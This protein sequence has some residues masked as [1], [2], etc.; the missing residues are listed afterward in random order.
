MNF[1]DNS[2][3]K[4]VLVTFASNKNAKAYHFTSDVIAF[5]DK[6]DAQVWARNLSNKKV[7][8]ITRAQAAELEISG[9]DLSKEMQAASEAENGKLEVPE[10]GNEFTDAL[11]SSVGTVTSEPE[12]P[13][14][15]AAPQKE[16]NKQQ[17]EPQVKEGT[18]DKTWNVPDI[19]AWLKKREV[20]FASNA[21]KAALLDKVGEYLANKKN[22]ST[23]TEE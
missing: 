12:A 5:P 17:E 20:K 10:T 19:K 15:S 13:K 16:E 9:K 6:E 7:L 21:T 14:P 4:K 8:Y 11:T 1:P 3:E 18:P 22:T 23:K 2:F